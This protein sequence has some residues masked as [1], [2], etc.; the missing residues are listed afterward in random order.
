LRRRFSGGKTAELSSVG[1]AQMCLYSLTETEN[2][3]SQA[4][5]TPRCQ[6]E[7]WDTMRRSRR[8]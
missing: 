2:G 3:I 4:A 5:P 6:G 1:S 7:P 8:R